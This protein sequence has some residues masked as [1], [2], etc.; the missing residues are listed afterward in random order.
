MAGIYDYI[1]KLKELKRRCI[2]RNIVWCLIFIY[3]LS[4]VELCVY[5]CFGMVVIWGADS[6]PA[7]TLEDWLQLIWYLFIKNVIGI[8]CKEYK[9][10]KVLLIEKIARHDPIVAQ[11]LWDR[12][13][14]LFCKDGLWYEHYA[15]KGRPKRRFH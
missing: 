9:T 15:K 2:I 3:F 13:P 6:I 1:E 12:D 14:T 10:Q 8:F 7:P 5:R 4:C 11:I